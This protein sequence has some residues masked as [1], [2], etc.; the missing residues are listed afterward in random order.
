MA[1]LA[2]TECGNQSSRAVACPNCGNPITG[3]KEFAA[4]GTHITTTQATAKKFKVHKLI[5]TGIILVGF[6]VFFSTLKSNPFIGATILVLGIVWSLTAL[7][8]SWWHHG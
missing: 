2:C 8:L 7:L 1:L 6:V 3:E 5:G 4:T